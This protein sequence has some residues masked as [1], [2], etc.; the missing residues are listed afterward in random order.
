VRIVLDALQAV[1]VFLG[2]LAAIIK[3][4]HKPRPGDTPEAE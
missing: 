1:G 4:A 3:I 2:G